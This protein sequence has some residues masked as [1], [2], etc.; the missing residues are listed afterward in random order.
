MERRR[1]EKCYIVISWMQAVLKPCCTVVELFDETDC[2]GP[3]ST[4]SSRDK[5]VRLSYHK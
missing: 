3:F 2:L 4:G 5:A 1:F